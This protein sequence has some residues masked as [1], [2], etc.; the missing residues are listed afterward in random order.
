MPRLLLLLPATTYRAE[1]F[2]EAAHRLKLDVT[3]ASDEAILQHLR[4]YQDFLPLRLHDLEDSVRTVTAFSRQHPVDVVIGVD[5]RTAVLAARIAAALGL[6]HNSA[7][8]VEAAHN[9]H[10][11]RQLLH[12]QEVPVPRF[13]VWGLDADPVA[14]AGTISF[15]CVVKPLILSASCGVIRA[16]NAEEFV[17]AFERAAALLRQLGL[18]ATEDAGRQLLVEEF[19][20]GREVA[21]EGLL[22]NGELHAL[23]LFDKP[24]PLDG[25]F[26]EETIYVTP[27]RL[28][29]S[30]QSEIASW[31]GR[32]ARALGLR[33]GPV[34][35]EFRIND[36]GVWVIELA[37]RSIGGRCSQTLRFAAGLSLEE[38]ILRHAFRMEL[39]AL[40]RVG[41]AAGVMMLPIP[42]GGIFS[43]VRGLAAA[44]AVPGIEALEITA[45]PGEPLVPLPEGTRYLG[46]MIAR[47]DT[48][49]RVEAALREA[50]RH[51]DVVVNAAPADA[52]RDQVPGTGRRVVRF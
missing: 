49:E 7:E 22:T 15:P 43:G 25:P 48:P 12:E 16:N 44:R 29:A 36:R 26:F 51:L 32:A 17:T 6:P 10:R 45:V 9:K 50:H 52:P 40:E 34:H 18:A 28:L 23:A 39:P 41:Q 42:Y 14:L 35:G 11:M 31:A 21:V 24:D 2:L 47:G 37:A 20:P 46:F 1:A 38:L 33:E 3:V 5:D 27:S 4:Q 19:V 30:L 8:S 13:A